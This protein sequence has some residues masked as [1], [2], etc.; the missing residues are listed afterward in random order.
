LAL[1][2]GIWTALQTNYWEHWEP[3]SYGIQR[4]IA[5]EID[6]LAN[7]IWLRLFKKPIDTLP[8]FDYEKMGRLNTGFIDIARN[9]FFNAEWFEVYDFMEFAAKNGTDES[10]E[11]FA[12]ISNDFLE[13]ENSAY[14][15][16]NKE[17]VQITDPKEIAEIEEA[18]VTGNN[19][20][21]KHLDTALNFLSDRKS[22]DYRNSIKESIS[23][24][25]SL[26]MT[27][28]D[29]GKATLGDTIKKLDIGVHLALQ[30]GFSSIYGY[31]SDASGIRHGILDEPK[32]SFSDAKF[33]L[34]A[35]SA[36]V[37]YLIGK[38]AEKK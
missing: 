37:N 16:V 19:A 4:G 12:R 26:C 6:L 11:S 38:Q 3:S 2:N 9:Y 15:L 24:V 23:A 21:R 35:C 25:E 28:T 33:M 13:S 17:I 14:R 36:F 8:A 34:V 5:Q 7:R 1:R 30:K 27:I 10:Y 29:N 31:T 18:T 20:V 22:P 32:H